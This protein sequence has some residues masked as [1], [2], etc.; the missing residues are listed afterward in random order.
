MEGDGLHQNKQDFPVYQRCSWFGKQ[1]LSFLFSIYKHFPPQGP[2]DYE[3]RLCYIESL[4]F[5]CSLAP[6]HPF[7]IF[8]ISSRPVSTDD[9]EVNKRTRPLSSGVCSLAGTTLIIKL[10][11]CD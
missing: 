4:S 6:F 5:I 3:E 2:C 8:R 10:Y 7:G 11:Y 1:I 9:E